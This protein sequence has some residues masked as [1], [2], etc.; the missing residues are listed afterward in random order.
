MTAMAATVASYGASAIFRWS[1][2]AAMM[3]ATIG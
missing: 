3:P 1:A 2:A